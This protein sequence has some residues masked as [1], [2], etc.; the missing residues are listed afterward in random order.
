M[1]RPISSPLRAYMIVTVVGINEEWIGCEPREMLIEL[2]TDPGEMKNLA[3]DPRHKNV[4]IQ[5]RHLLEKWYEQH[6]EILEEKYIV[7]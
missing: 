5:H 4:I 1:L 2:K 7:S 6:G 3:V